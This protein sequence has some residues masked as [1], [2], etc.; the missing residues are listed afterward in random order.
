TRE[1]SAT[2]AGSPAA[3]R[4]VV[5]V[6]TR[7]IGAVFDALASHSC[8]AMLLL[9]PQPP[10][11]RV[12]AVA[13]GG[14]GDATRGPCGAHRRPGRNATRSPGGGHA[15]P[16]PAAA[17]APGPRASAAQLPPP[18]HVRPEGLR[19]GQRV[20]APSPIRP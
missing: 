20:A 8:R 3:G 13:A 5:G 4:S 9:S 15:R 6:A 19:A 2:R 10:P 1:L 11:A 12:R 17:A 16:L 14:P 18:P 7:F